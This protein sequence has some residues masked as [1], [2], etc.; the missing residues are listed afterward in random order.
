MYIKHIHYLKP[1]Y[2]G[3]VFC[4]EHYCDDQRSF[5][6]VAGRYQEDQRSLPRWSE[7]ITKMITGHYQHD[8]RSNMI[9]RSLPGWSDVNTEMISGPRWSKV[10]TKTIATH[11]IHV[12][13]DDHSQGITKLITGPRWSEV[14][15]T[16]MVRAYYQDDLLT[17]D[18]HVK[19]YIF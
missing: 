14:N 5:T 13:R 8:R 3:S 15:V 1:S 18:I 11:Y 16:N 4:R 6:K 2:T 19:Q 9:L 17:P 10:I 7:V 12:G